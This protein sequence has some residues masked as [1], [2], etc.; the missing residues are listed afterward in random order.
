MATAALASGALVAG[1]VPQG[2]LLE[3]LGITARARA[4][5]RALTG[6]ALEAHVAAHRRL[7]H[8]EGMGSLVQALAV[9]DRDP[10]P[11]GFAP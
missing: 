4:L 1:P 3:R 8:P 10:G 11:P 2:V 9:F 7:T 6:P 5:A